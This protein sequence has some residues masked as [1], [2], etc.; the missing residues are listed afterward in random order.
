[1]TMEISQDKIVIG[2]HTFQEFQ[3]NTLAG[4]Q[5]TLHLLSRLLKI[6]PLCLMEW[7]MSRI[8][9]IRRQ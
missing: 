3:L 6:S 7:T 9:L 4:L 8:A 1:M 2:R 5:W